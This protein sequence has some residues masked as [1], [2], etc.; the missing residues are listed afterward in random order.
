MRSIAVVCLTFTLGILASG[1]LHAHHSFAT[2]YILDQPIELT[3]VVTEVT[4]RNPHSFIMMDVTDE[5]GV[6]EEWEVEIHSVPLMRRFGV[7][8]DT[9]QPGD[10][11]QIVG[12]SPRHGFF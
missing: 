9:I 1:Q 6:T 12:P 11:L 8:A 5:Q 7:T 4:L 2:H 3:G 10:T